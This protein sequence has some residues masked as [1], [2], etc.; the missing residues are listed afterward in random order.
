MKGNY[1]PLYW[2]KDINMGIRLYSHTKSMKST[3]TLQLNKVNDAFKGYQIIYG[4]MPCLNYESHEDKLH[5]R[6]VDLMKTRNSNGKDEIS[7]EDVNP[8][9]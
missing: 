1:Y 4:A 7:M 9:D 6:Y 8:D 2:G 5:D 3:G